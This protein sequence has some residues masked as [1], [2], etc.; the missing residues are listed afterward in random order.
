MKKNIVKEKRV[1]NN[2]TY[3]TYSLISENGDLLS[4]IDV[5]K[6]ILE[7]KIKYINE[8]KDKNVLYLT[9]FKTVSRFRNNGYGRYLLKNI[10]QRFKGKYEVIHLNACPYYEKLFN[11]EYKAPNNG[12]KIKKLVKFYE[13]FGF[14]KHHMKRCDGHT[15][16]IMILKNEKG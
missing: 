15:E 11:I 7:D 9:C 2:G 8:Y 1:Y 5:E 10:L 3:Y 6:E 13:S 4:S 12:L 14:K 16:V